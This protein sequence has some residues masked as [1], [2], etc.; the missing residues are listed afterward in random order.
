MS[1]I[2]MRAARFHQ[3]N[4]NLHLD[5]VEIPEPSGDE[6]LVRVRAAGVCHT[7]VHIRNGM[8]PLV[9]SIP[10]PLTLG[11]ENAGEI[12]RLGPNAS[13][14]REGDSVVVWGARG[15]GI[16]RLCQSGD[17]NLC[18]QGTWLSGGYADYVLVPSERYLAR[19]DGV[20]PV[21]AAPLAD[22]GLTPLHAIRKVL[23]RLRAGDPVVLFGV[24]G[25]GH[26]AI[27]ILRA[28]SPASEII[29]VDVEP[30]KLALARELGAHHAVDGREDPAGRIR[31]IV[32]AAGAPAVLDFVGTDATLAASLQCLGTAGML[33]MVGL[34]G[35]TLAVSPFAAAAEAVVTSSMWGSFGELEEV[36]VLAREGLIRCTT[37]VFDLEQVNVALDGV[38]SG[39]IAGRAVLTP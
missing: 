27:Q 32:G 37:S 1:S 20:D 7:D 33:V 17:E 14:L 15:C 29:A 25:L 18:G 38:E 2:N 3:P 6:V 26:M 30:E 10:L 22:A 36:L 39:T 4:E 31:Q 11:H 8:I 12:A 9:P 35:G 5:D 34:G 13:V 28:L 24:G 19:L 23:P 16:C 21:Q